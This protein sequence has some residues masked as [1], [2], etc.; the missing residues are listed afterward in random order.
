MGFN[1]TSHQLSAWQIDASDKI[2]NKMF[3]GDY[4]LSNVPDTLNKL[5]IIGIGTRILPDIDLVICDSLVIDS[6]TVDNTIF[7]NYLQVGG[8]IIGKNGFSFLAGST[9]SII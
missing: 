5:K 6:A 3:Q 7:H 2:F 8:N 4:S 1:S 9:W